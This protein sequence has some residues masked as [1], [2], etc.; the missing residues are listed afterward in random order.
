[1]IPFFIKFSGGISSGIIKKWRF[2]LNNCWSDLFLKPLFVEYG[3]IYIQDG[4]SNLII[5]LLLPSVENLHNPYKN[6]SFMVSFTLTNTRI[7]KDITYFF[8]RESISNFEFSISQLEKDIF[9]ISI[10]IHNDEIDIISNGVFISGLF[11]KEN[12]IFGFVY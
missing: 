5:S 1:M 2:I 8:E 11:K 12:E 3:K 10:N 7:N 4:S 6:D 9:N